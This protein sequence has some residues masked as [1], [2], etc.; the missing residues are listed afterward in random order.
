MPLAPIAAPRL[1]RRIADTSAAAIDAGEFVPGQRLPGERELARR[2]AVSRSS[3]RE[4]LSALEL[5]GHVEIR[6]GSGVYVRARRRRRAPPAA[7]ADASAP[8][9]VLRA[10]RVV[11]AETAALAARHATPAQVRAIEQAFERLAADMRANRAPSAGDRLFHVRI[12]QASG[13]TAL[14]DVVANL[15]RAQRDPLAARMEALFVT[16]SRR[17][18]NI[19][20]HRRILE[21]I[22]AGD[23]GGARRAMREHLANA[24]RQRLALLRAPG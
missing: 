20:E 17:R 15:W 10:R 9:D 19:G 14:A 23:A 3:L 1:Y 12:A 6:V 5:E 18:D 24:E 13:N 11:E 8:F 2:L 21:A 7:A 16:G 4:A 22:R